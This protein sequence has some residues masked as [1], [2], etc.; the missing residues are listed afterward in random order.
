MNDAG[1]RSGGIVE[2]V[3]KPRLEALRGT[4][5]LSNEVEGTVPVHRRTS[6]AL[7]VA[8]ERCPGARPDADRRVVVRGRPEFPNREQ[9]A[10]FGREGADAGPI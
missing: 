10:G 8:P 3:A 9:G 7:D 2:A 5:R 1:E 6:V 4:E